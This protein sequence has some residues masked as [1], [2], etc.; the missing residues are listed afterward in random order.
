MI[1]KALRVR[2]ERNAGASIGATFFGQYHIAGTAW[3]WI[4]LAG[5]RLIR[6]CV[7]G[8]TLWTAADL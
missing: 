4:E 5:S 8:F 1:D 6:T 3:P 2:G 7:K